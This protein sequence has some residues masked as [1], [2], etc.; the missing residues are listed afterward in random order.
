MSI[1]PVFTTLGGPDPFDTRLAFLLMPDG[2]ERSQQLQIQGEQLQTNL[3][4]QLLAKDG[5]LPAARYQFTFTCPTRAE[6]KAL[7]TFWRACNARYQTFFFPTWDFEFKIPA[8]PSSG[9]AFLYL[10]S[11]SILPS[12]WDLNSASYRV[13]A[14]TRGGGIRIHPINSYVL[15]SPAGFDQFQINTTLASLGPTV[16]DGTWTEAEG[17][18]LLWF[19]YGR[20]DADTFDVTHDLSTGGGTV[21]LAIQE[22]PDELS[23]IYPY[24]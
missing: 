11:G 3:T 16:G 17:T 1:L 15:N 23:T 22:L 10:P 14:V 8:S 20:F 12:Y 13:I 6:L 19:R 4:L 24:V 7:R 21:T 5:S 9:G 18:R 2:A